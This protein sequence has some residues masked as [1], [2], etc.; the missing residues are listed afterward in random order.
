MSTQLE[1]AVSS[2]LSAPAD[3]VWHSAVTPGGLNYE[4]LPLARMTFPRGTTQFLTSETVLGVPVCRSW[5]LLFGFLPV[6]FDDMTFIELGPGCRFLE[7]STMLTQRFW[8]HERTVEDCPGGCRIT[9]RVRFTPRLPLFRRLQRLA[10]LT[11]FRLR[12]YKLRRR[13]G[14]P[15]NQA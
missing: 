6:D 12:H 14:R 10:F 13:Y 1:F 5:I 8:Q 15:P 3:T 4:L 11:A 7:R 2:L 9:D